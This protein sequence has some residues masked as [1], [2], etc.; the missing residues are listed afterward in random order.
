[1]R[2][3]KGKKIA[4]KSVRRPAGLAK[5][6]ALAERD[7]DM[8]FLGDIDDTTYDDALM[9]SVEVPCGGHRALYDY[10]KCIQCLMDSYADGV[11]NKREQAIEWMEFNVVGA[12]V[13]D[14]G[15]VFFHGHPDDDE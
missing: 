5:K 3:S 13:G 1:M 6:E 10:D 2:K 4:L 9:G 7:P 14:K 15:P 8:M 12:F 11:E